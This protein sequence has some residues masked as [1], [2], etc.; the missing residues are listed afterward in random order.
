MKLQ[1]N[2]KETEIKDGAN[3]TELLVEQQVKMP[4]MVSVELNDQILKREEF[5]ATVLNEGDRVEF[6]YFMGGGY[7]AE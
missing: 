6:I 2:G 3:V 5:D 7:V 4:E 1:I